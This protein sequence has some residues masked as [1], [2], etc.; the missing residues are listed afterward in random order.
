[1]NRHISATQRST[2]TFVDL[3]GRLN[4]CRLAPHHR[5]QNRNK[6]SAQLVYALPKLPFCTGSPKHFQRFSG[7]KQGLKKLE[8]A[9]LAF[10]RLH[11][12]RGQAASLLEGVEKA[13][14]RILWQKAVEGGTEYA[15]PETVNANTL[16]SPYFAD[17]LTTAY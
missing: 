13:R 8:E 12:H 15:T 9:C 3:I 2:E 16:R 4:R 11:R 14:V 5:T 6:H 7:P 10:V 1:M 17:C